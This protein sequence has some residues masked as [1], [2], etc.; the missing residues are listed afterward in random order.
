[1]MSETVPLDQTSK[2]DIGFAFVM[3]VVERG[4]VDLS[5]SFY[6]EHH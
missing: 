3:V 5:D 1:M 4:L 6:V 2:S